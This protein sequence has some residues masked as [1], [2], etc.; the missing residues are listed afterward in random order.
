MTADGRS[1]E[2]FYREASVAHAMAGAPA[3]LKLLDGFIISSPENPDLL[4]R[5]AE[6]NC[7]LQCADRARRP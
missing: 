3:L 4:I 5:A 6:L 2:S 7:G 1:K